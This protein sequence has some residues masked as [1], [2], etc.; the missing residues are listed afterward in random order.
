MLLNPPGFISALLCRTHERALLY[1]LSSV[2]DTHTRRAVLC[3]VCVYTSNASIYSFLLHTHTHTRAQQQQ[4][5]WAP[6]HKRKRKCLTH[7]GNDSRSRSDV[8]SL[9]PRHTHTHTQ[10]DGAMGGFSVASLPLTPTHPH[11][12]WASYI[13][14]ENA[15]ANHTHNKHNLCAVGERGR[16]Q[17]SSYFILFLGWLF[18]ISKTKSIQERI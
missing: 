11:S 7:S 10:W 12:P 2:T 14:W 6:Q 8:L 16:R 1:T 13:V 3:C 15:R 4:E 17:L 18:Y 9:L 5:S